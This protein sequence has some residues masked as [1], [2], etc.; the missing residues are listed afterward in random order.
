MDESAPDE[1]AVFE[2]VRIA[3]PTFALAMMTGFFEP[4]L[5]VGGSTAPGRLFAPATL[6]ATGASESIEGETMIADLLSASAS[7]RS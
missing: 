7:E 5:S 3:L 1:G 6:N 4:K 2:I